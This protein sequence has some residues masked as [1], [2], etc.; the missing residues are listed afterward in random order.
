MLRINEYKTEKVTGDWGKLNNEEL[1]NSV[2][3]IK[4]YCDQIEEDERARVATRLG[5]VRNL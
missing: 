4:Y 5:D 3:V 2:F 1:H